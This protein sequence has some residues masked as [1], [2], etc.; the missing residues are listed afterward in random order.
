MPAPNRDTHTA[1]PPVRFYSFWAINAPLDPR[2]LREQLDAFKSAGLDGVVFHPRFYPDAPPYLGDDYLRLVSDTILHAKALGLAFWLYDENGWPSGTVGGRMLETHPSL[3][4]RWAGLFRERP[5]RVLTEFERDGARWHLGERV[6]RGVDY[7]NPE[8]ARRFIEMTHERY[9]RG[10]APEAWAHVEAFF[11]DEP[12]FGLGHA[13]DDLPPDGALPWTPRLPELWRERH[14]EEL[15][16]RLPLLFFPGEGAAET[17]ARFWELLADVFNESF[18]APLDAWCRAHD[19]RLAAHVKGEEHPLFQLPTSGSCHQVFRRLSLP[20][21]DA[22]E[23]FPTNN[24]YPRQVSSAARQ[25]GDG[26]CMAEAFGGSGW[27]AGPADLERHLLWLGANGLTDFVLHLGQYRLDSAAL[28]DWPPSQPLH[29]TWSAAYRD[30]L[31]AVRAA[32]SARP[33]PPADTLVIAPCRGIAEAYSPAEFVRT[34][35]H[36]ASTH[37]DSPAARI[38]RGFLARIETLARAGVAYDVADE[39]SVET[40]G[41]ARADGLRLGNCVYRQVIADPAARLAPRASDLVRPWLIDLAEACPRPTEPSTTPPAEPPASPTGQNAPTTIEWRLA[42]EPVNRLMLDCE[43]T[44]EADVFHAS[45][46]ADFSPD[47]TPPVLRFA[48]DITEP[49]LNGL[50]LVCEP[51]PDGEGSRATPPASS[52]RTINR[53]V[54]RRARPGPRPFAWLEGRFR[55]RSHAAFASGPGATVKTDGPFV[56]RAVPRDDGPVSDLLDLG[57]PFLRATL[58]LEARV[59]LDRPARELRLLGGAYDA[60]R[61]VIDGR[62]LGWAWPRDGEPRFSPGEP[63]APGPRLLA[64]ELAPNGFNAY[65]PHHY[66]A[67]D[68]H[69]VSPDQIAGRRGFADPEGA[70]A[71]THVAAWHFRPFSPPDKLVLPA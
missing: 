17:R 39:R 11:C 63:V 70:P 19:K 20:G 43:E 32:L 24:F 23:R 21:I 38:N 10:L 33:R 46:R 29:L 9:R 8:L 26:R 51:S 22:L 7:L 65:G 53:V 66:F 5:E 3:A 41:M 49:T 30:V 35:C 40:H 12:E 59:V 42:E 25:F 69:V 14:G 1:R 6:G 4:Q 71:R 2:R 45:F 50:A 54:F 62:D 15:A 55:A 47:A 27:G 37:P 28:H 68:R 52:L 57:F 48:D 34:N 58:R 31:D 18:V 16:P 60:A 56:A 13:Q 36:D 44:P 64:L 61:L 67:G